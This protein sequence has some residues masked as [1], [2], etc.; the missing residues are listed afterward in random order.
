M[1]RRFWILIA[2]ALCTPDLGRAQGQD[3]LVEL[4]RVVTEQGRHIERLERELARL[5]ASPGA[6]ARGSAARGVAEDAELAWLTRET[7]RKLKPGMSEAEVVA[8]LGPPTA[9]RGQPPASKTLLYTLEL[10][11]TGFLSG[12]VVLEDGRVRTITEPQ[13]R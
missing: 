7:W 12:T 6:R 1:K 4:A 8:V 2:Y 13:L 9:V 3:V 5:K 11:G 10:E